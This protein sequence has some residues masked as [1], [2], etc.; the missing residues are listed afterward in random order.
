VCHFDT[1][2]LNAFALGYAFAL[3]LL[4]PLG[5]GSFVQNNI[6]VGFYRALSD[7]LLTI[8]IV[9]S[10]EMYDDTLLYIFGANSAIAYT[11]SL[12]SPFTY[13][14]KYNAKLKQ[15]LNIK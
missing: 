14:N 10:N 5:I 1:L 7:V 8:M 3:N 12:I 4:L 9:V 11:V 15:K 2:Y 6:G 13:Q